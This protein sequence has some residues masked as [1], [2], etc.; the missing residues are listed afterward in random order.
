MADFNISEILGSLS[1]DDM[2]NLK[3]IADGL[4]GNGAQSKENEQDKQR[5]ES[6]GFDLNSAKLPD[7][8]VLEKL[9]PVLNAL[10]ANDE[11]TRL[12]SSL[13]PMLSETR[14]KKADEAIK[15]IKL[16]T[17]IPVLKQNGNL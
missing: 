4:L 8:S 16:L 11:R 7:I 12:I 9:L 17:V 3:K 15:I 6:G 1:E 10:D 14:Q 5:R 2:N 13:K